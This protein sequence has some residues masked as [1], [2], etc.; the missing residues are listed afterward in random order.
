MVKERDDMY[1]QES[2]SNSVPSLPTRSELRAYAHR[3]IKLHPEI[4]Q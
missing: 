1:S 4:K 3:K 2:T